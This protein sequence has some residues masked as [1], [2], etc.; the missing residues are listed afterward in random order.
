LVVIVVAIAGIAA[1]IMFMAVVSPFANAEEIH[2]GD[3]ITGTIVG[4]G[5]DDLYKIK[6]QPG[7]V[8]SAKLSGAG[9]TDF[10]L[11]AYENVLFWDEYIITG[12]ANDTSNEALSVVAW[13]ND[14]YILDVYSYVGGG[15][16]TLNVDIVDTINLD[17]G[18]NSIS[19]ATQISSGTPVTSGLN[20]YYDTD[21]YYKIFVNSGQILH[22]YLEVPTQANTDFDLYIYDSS[23]SQVGVSENAYGNEELSIYATASGNYYVNAWAYDGIG[24]YTLSVETQTGTGTDS[25][26]DLSTAEGIA[27]GGQVS[28]TLSEYNDVDD[29]YRINVP[30]GQTITA[31]MTG[32]ANAD[33]DLYLYNDAGEIIASSK[34]YTSSETI[35]YT[36]QSSGTYYVNPSAY[37]GFGTYT[38]RVT[39]GSG[40]LSLK[41]SAGYD[42]TVGVGQTVS[43]DGS[44]STGA[45][46]SYDW[47][48][49]DSAT[50]A[51]ATATH[52]YGATGTYTVTLTVSDGSATATDTIT[53]TVQTAGTMPNKY[54]V[55]IGISDYQGDNDLTYCDED[56]NTW[57]AYLEAQGYTV[58]TLIDS[59]ATSTAIFN[60]I[61]WME[62]Q[63]E[64]GDYVAFV[65][66]GHGYY[67]DRERS[68]SI[69][70]WNIEEQ[71]GLIYDAELG[72]AFENFDS[73]HIFMF[74][75]SCYSGGMDG[76]AGP[77][78]YLSQTAGQSELG[79]D[80][81]K[82]Q[83]GMWVY[84]FLEY[85]I[86]EMGNSDLTRAYDVAYPQAVSDAAAANNPMHPE[87]EWS[88]SGGF[89]L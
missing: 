33:F 6:L 14:F 73:Q 8:V 48:F 79:L 58:H 5:A 38:L 17:D 51:G 15:D 89:Y 28:A 41:A 71:D 7:E 75:D 43:F 60:E 65:F 27:N 24:F 69:C 67:S 37:G 83:H 68:S 4:S 61:K 88:G 35:V 70:A 66:S 57:T 55:V 26:N 44:G 20:E 50:G 30:A 10:D 46:S 9:G 81:P 22:A 72:T 64:A 87:E 25:N 56:A 21:D 42:R 12:S 63:E 11:Y 39:L 1:A 84:W 36:V 19:E 32:P 31:T 49:G 18:D 40:G 76:A 85:A 29:Y 3:T 52:S 78:R 53:I 45:I 16:Y 54:A 59:Q 82:H 2:D 77:G 13:E 47:D 34:E 80:A 62:A 86:K 74:F 23:E